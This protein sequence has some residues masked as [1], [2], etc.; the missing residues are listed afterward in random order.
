MK[1]IAYT[2]DANGKLVFG[3]PTLW[4]WLRATWLNG[5]LIKL[6][7]IKRHERYLPH[8]CAYQLKSL[9]YANE[10]FSGDPITTIAWAERGRNDI[11]FALRGIED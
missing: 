5:G 4:S 3:R 6:K 8:S 9:R 2:V 10:S 7:P 1:I 11:S